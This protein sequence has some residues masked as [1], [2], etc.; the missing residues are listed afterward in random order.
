MGKASM[1]I[2]MLELL[3]TGRVYKVSDLG[4]LL[5]TN[6]R[7]IIEYRKELEEAGYYIISI[8]GKYGGY[9]LSKTNII[10][11][12]KF[13]SSE[14]NS[15]SDAVGYLSARNDFYKKKGFEKAM[16]KVF[17]SMSHSG[18]GE[19]PT[20]INRFPLSM[21]E[22]D[23]IKRYE[24]LRYCIN[25]KL[26]I[27]FVYVSQKNTEK[28]Y[29]FDPYELFMY[30]NAWFILG[31]NQNIGCV[32]Y[33]KINRIT[34]YT[35]TDK[36]FN[37]WKGFNRN[38]YIDE[39]GFKSNGEWYHI[40]FKALN[41]YASLVK[42]RIYGKNQEVIPIDEKTTLVKVDMQNKENILVF[43]LGFNKNIEILE[44]QWLKDELL[45][46]SKFLSKTYKKGEK[47]WKMEE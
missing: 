14:I 22:E 8:P 13:T 12:I 29:I 32:S 27:D 9:K 10:P 36:R 24:A 47:E 15:I 20:V 1:C 42:E 30:N 17:S 19:T 39:Y 40:E 18:E 35:I 26:S 21:P 31:W 34:K 16:G 4:E 11:A 37:I 44:P 7:N 33:F 41:T 46:Y 28:E 43:I 3:N 5:E 6:P 2:Q 38:D 23:L 25:N 45:E